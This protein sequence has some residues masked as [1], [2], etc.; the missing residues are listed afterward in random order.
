MLSII[1]FMNKVIGDVI[2]KIN[3][4]DCGG[5]NRKNSYEINITN[6]QKQE[7]IKFL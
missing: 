6:L 5:S 1:N 3:H 4:I 7:I 2:D